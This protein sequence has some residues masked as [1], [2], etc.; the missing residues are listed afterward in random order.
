M[1]LFQSLDISTSGLV[2]N[3]VWMDTISSNI[4]NMHNTGD[5]AGRAN[6]YKR[7]YPVFVARQ[8]GAAT[9][10]GVMDVRQDQAQGQFVEAPEGHPHR[11]ETGPYA[12]MV[13]MP[14]VE[15]ATEMANAIVALNSYQANVTA[16]QVTKQ[17]YSADL[18]ILA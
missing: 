8:N 9:G 2:A 3:R 1:N 10:V 4:A 12:G 15:Y 13:E 11:I 7:R 5:P 18:R 14:N 17:M 16:Q 6:P